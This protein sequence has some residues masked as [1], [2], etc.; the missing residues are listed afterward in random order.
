MQHNVILY[1][2]LNPACC[3]SRSINKYLNFQFQYSLTSEPDSRSKATYTKLG[4]KQS[5]KLFTFV[6]QDL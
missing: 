3:L 5:R 6:A 1:L 2:G 4:K